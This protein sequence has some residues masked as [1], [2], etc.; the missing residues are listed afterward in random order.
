MCSEFEKILILCPEDWIEYTKNL[1]KKHVSDTDR[2]EVI[3]GGA[4]RNET[5]MNSI[6][7]ID[8]AGHLDDD[9]VIVTH[10]AVRPF[11][12]YR[13]L[14]A[15]IDAA[16]RYGACDTVIPA[17]GYDSREQERQHHIRYTGQVGPLS[18]PDAAELQGCE[19]A[20]A[21]RGPD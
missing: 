11:V 4:T 12:T 17:N 16:Q 1:I 9:T 15:N 8:D 7:Y 18:G 2:I 3:E 6:A 14:K 13:I 21:L 20:C 5:I 19:A 10:D